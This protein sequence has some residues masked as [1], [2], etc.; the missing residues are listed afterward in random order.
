MNTLNNTS[1][2]SYYESLWT[3]DE[4]GDYILCIFRRS[5]NG[6][7]NYDS[8]PEE[9]REA[10]DEAIAEYFPDFEN[11]GE[12]GMEKNIYYYTEAKG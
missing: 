8:I 7:E 12:D 5:F 3:K 2:D 11:Y 6:E 4:N 9:V 1:E 10:A